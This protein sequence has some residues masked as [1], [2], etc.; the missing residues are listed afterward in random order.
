E[1]AVAGGAGG[2]AA[3]QK[4]LLR[5]K[6][7]HARRR[8]GGDD[9]APR[10]EIPMRIERQTERAP[11]QV[12]RRGLTGQVLRAETRRLLA[13]L[14]DQLRPLDPLRE[15]GEVLHVG[16][17]TELPARLVA[18]DQE[19]LQVGAGGVDRRRQAGA[20]RPQDDDASGVRGRSRTSLLLVTSA[21]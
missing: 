14:L 7:E 10:V 12:D 6:P 18:V 21:E 11:R 19:R 3:A 17:E 8:S 16:R 1:E 5:R 2:H 9:E 15:A 20:P 4:T 13:H